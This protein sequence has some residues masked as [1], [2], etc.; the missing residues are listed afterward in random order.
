MRKNKILFL[1][2]TLMSCSLV[3]QNIGSGL[4]TF[5][6]TQNNSKSKSLFFSDRFSVCEEEGVEYISLLAKLKKDV[7]NSDVLSY[8]C[9]ITSSSGKIV[10]MR[11]RVDN[12]EELLRSGLFERI[13]VARIPDRLHS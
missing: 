5:L 12:I 10:C 7:E 11:A 9:K 3:A 8:D 2:L 13:D 6:S 4:K 1:L